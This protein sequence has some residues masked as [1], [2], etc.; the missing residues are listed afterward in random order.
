[1]RRRRLLP[2]RSLLTTRLTARVRSGLGRLRL[3][4]ITPALGGLVVL[5]VLVCVAAVSWPGRGHELIWSDEFDGPRGAPP[6]P[7]KWRHD[8]GAHW[9]NGTQLQ[10]YTDGTDNSELDGEG[11]VLLTTKATVIELPQDESK[12]GCQDGV[13][14]YTSARLVTSGSFSHAHGVFEARIKLPDGPVWPAFWLLGDSVAD[15]GW[16]AAGEIDIMEV[17]RGGSTVTGSVHGPFEHRWPNNPFSHEFTLPNG[18]RFSD[19]FHV[20]AVEWQPDRIIWLVDG[21]PYGTT[22]KADVGAKRWVFDEPFHILLNI[23]VP[24]DPGGRPTDDGDRAGQTMA[25]D[26]VRVYDNS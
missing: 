6:D 11:N 8:V 4:R 12:G 22:T 25:V 16:P 23:A 14:R 19:G 7:A 1:M 21:V 13:C 9:G 10:Y 26:Y 24:V 17:G 18:Q 20:F 15:R 5:G 3:P 2:A